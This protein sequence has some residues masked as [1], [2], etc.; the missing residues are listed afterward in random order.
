MCAV[1]YFYRKSKYAISHSV[2]VTLFPGY[3]LVCPSPS[4]QRKGK[5]YLCI[6]R[7]V[8]HSV[9]KARLQHS[10]DGH[11]AR[12]TS[13][14]LHIF[15][16]QHFNFLLLSDPMFPFSIFISL[17]SNR[18]SSRNNYCEISQIIAGNPCIWQNIEFNIPEILKNVLRYLANNWQEKY[19]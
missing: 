5:E 8:A 13:I 19:R 7:K 9:I 10:F 2:S 15:S 18:S 16:L 12:D 6:E 14:F 4:G 11:R 17:F 1:S 3:R